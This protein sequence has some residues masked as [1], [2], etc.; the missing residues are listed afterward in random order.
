MKFSILFTALLVGAVTA[1]PAGSIFID[2]PTEEAAASAAATGL[3]CKTLP[4]DSNTNTNNNNNNNN[5]NNGNNGNANG[6]ANG[7]FNGNT[8]GNNANTNDNN[9]NNGNSN[10]LPLFP[11]GQGDDATNDAI[12]QLQS[13]FDRNNPNGTPTNPGNPADLNG[14]GVINLFEAGAQ[15]A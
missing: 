6:N 8:N 9:N 1:A 5:N 7:N 11:V 10:G 12:A 15:A 14:D 3:R 2:C 13:A 4:G